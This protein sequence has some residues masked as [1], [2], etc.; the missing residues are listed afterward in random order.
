MLR[1]RDLIDLHV[2]DLGGDASISAA[3]RAIVQRAA[4]LICELERMERAFALAGEAAPDALDLYQRTAGNMRRLLESVGL[5]RRT[6]DITPD[7]PTY[8]ASVARKAA[9]NPSDTNHTNREE[10]P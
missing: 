9:E 8:L 5:D 2:S 7:L 10:T 6:K 4:T 1:L 3:E